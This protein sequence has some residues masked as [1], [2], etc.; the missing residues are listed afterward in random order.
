MGDFTQA[1]FSYKYANWRILPPPKAWYFF[2][3]GTNQQDPEDGPSHV[4]RPGGLTL[5]LLGKRLPVTSHLNLNGNWCL[6]FSLSKS[7]LDLPGLG[8]LGALHN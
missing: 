4:R 1:T 3:L 6:Q 5:H 2:P 8:V 7:W